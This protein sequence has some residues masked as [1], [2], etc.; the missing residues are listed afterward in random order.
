MM[1]QGGRA[2][3]RPC[4][5]AADLMLVKAR[6]TKRYRTSLAGR[7]LIAPAADVSRR[8]FLETAGTVGDAAAF[9]FAKPRFLR[10]QDAV[11]PLK[12]G[13]FGPVTGPASRTGDEFK[14]G[15]ALALEDARAAGDLPLTIDG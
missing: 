14:N 1:G 4:A 11:E 10:A 2:V 12:I 6:T 9:L 5:G 8:R 3:A 7:S 13:S 15:V